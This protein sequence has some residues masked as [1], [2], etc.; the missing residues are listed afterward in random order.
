MHYEK[1]ISELHFK[2]LILLSKIIM[3]ALGT[4]SRD[5]KFIETNTK[6]MNASKILA[7]TQDDNLPSK[8]QKEDRER[9]M[10]LISYDVAKALISHCMM[11]LQDCMLLTS[12]PKQSLKSSLRDL[13]FIRGTSRSAYNHETIE[14]AMQYLV[15]F[16]TFTSDLEK[17]L[18]R[19]LDLSDDHQMI[20]HTLLTTALGYQLKKQ[21]G[22]SAQENSPYQLESLAL[23]NHLQ[24][25]I[26]NI[27]SFNKLLGDKKLALKDPAEFD[28][29]I[30]LLL[31]LSTFGLLELTT[32]VLLSFQH[33][34]TSHSPPPP[35][36]DALHG[37][38]FTLA[39]SSLLSVLTRGW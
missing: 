17:R 21:E 22:E 2:K 7:G 33:L 16:V 14:K 20:L 38:L 35:L 1:V 3:R 28:L 26:Q 29:Y 8:F 6:K 13:T 32:Q 10:E 18:K 19:P 27:R 34:L 39:A 5:L 9:I 31:S 11:A 36:S 15:K 24:L 23:Y 37:H 25:K 4:E 12:L 30:A